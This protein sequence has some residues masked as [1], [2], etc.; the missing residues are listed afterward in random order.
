[1][2]NAGVVIG[3]YATADLAVG[4]YIVNV[5]LSDNQAT[6]N[7][8]LYNLT[9]EKQAISVTVR[10]LAAGLSGKLT[11]GDIVSVIVPD[12][13]KQG[14]TVVPSILQY[15]EI[16]AVTAG[17]GND[18]NTPNNTDN[19]KRELPSTVTLL[20]LPE[21]AKLLAE[22]EAEGKL[23][24]ALVYR[25]TSEDAALFIEIQ[26]KIIDELNKEDEPDNGNNHNPQNPH[27]NGED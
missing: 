26:D 17:N 3:K 21:Q 16:I 11:S 8:Y 7:T 6:E 20:A 19:E 2:K 15:V 22:L 9:G 4:D 12:F 5:K 18:A 23:H 25:G 13:R 24:L 10:S 14:V 27:N 1:M